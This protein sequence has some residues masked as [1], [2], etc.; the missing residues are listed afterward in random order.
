MAILRAKSDI[1]S[2]APSPVLGGHDGSVRHGIHISERT[3]PLSG[4]ETA[5]RLQGA[6]FDLD[7]ALLDRAGASLPGLDPFLSLMKVEDIW[8]YLVT[9]GSSAQARRVLDHSGLSPFFRG[10]LSAPEHGVS[11]TAPALYEKAVRRL[12]TAL[13]ATAVFT[14]REDMVPVLK[15]AGFPVVLVGPGHPPELQAM[16]DQVIEDYGAMTRRVEG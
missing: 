16:A 14:A 13:P 6:I 7:G 12:R 8:M 15:A 9:G 11:V 5:M 2:A 4:L 10:I 3:T 1:I